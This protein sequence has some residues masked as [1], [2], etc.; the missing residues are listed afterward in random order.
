MMFLKLN[1]KFIFLIIKEIVIKQLSKIYK[2][3]F[4]HS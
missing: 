4:Y 3:Y 2:L 1:I